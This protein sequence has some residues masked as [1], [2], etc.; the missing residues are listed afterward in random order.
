[1]ALR[2]EPAV[3]VPITGPRSRTL[4]APQRIGKRLGVPA[5]GWEVSRIWLPR[6]V[7]ITLSRTLPRLEMQ[8]APRRLEP[9]ERPPTRTNFGPKA[10]CWQGLIASP[11]ASIAARA[12]AA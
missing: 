7:L 12:L 5:P 4:G 6:F 11:E 3:T 8:K 9:N 1:M 2:S 10:A